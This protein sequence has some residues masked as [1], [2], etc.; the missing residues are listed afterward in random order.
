MIKYHS[1]NFFL[2][3]TAALLS[4]GQ[5]QSSNS[6]IFNSTRLIPLNAYPIEKYYQTVSSSQP[7][8]LR[9]WKPNILMWPI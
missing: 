7:D 9:H 2:N 3:A 6:P 8:Y 4:S 1:D 5:N